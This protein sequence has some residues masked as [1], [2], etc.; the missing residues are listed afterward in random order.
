VEGQADPKQSA[1]SRGTVHVPGRRD[2]LD[3]KYFFKVIFNWLT[4]IKRHD[5]AMVRIQPGSPAR[6]ADHR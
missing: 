1:G 2:L 5:R 3:R 6:P 4:K